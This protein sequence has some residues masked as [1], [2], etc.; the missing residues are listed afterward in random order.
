[1]QDTIDITKHLLIRL[2]G[3]YNLFKVNKKTEKAL[4]SVY[5]VLEPYLKDFA[6][7]GFKSN[8]V[9]FKYTRL[10]KILLKI[11]GEVEKFTSLTGR[12]KKE[13]VV[14]LLILVVDSLP[15]DKVARVTLIKILEIV[16]P[17]L[18]D[19]II[20]LTKNM[21]HAGVFKKMRRF[22]VKCLTCGHC[23]GACKD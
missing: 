22:L 2:E 23:C 7:E 17:P 9:D 1:M 4:V 20:E 18:I 6:E 10:N 15:V 8:F 13:V 21:K 12:E 5:S 14:D 19:Q 16:V 11:I 3:R